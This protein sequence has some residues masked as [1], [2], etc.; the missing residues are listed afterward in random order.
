MNSKSCQQ[1][2]L[3]KK[4]ERKMFATSLRMNFSFTHFFFYMLKYENI[5]I[6]YTSN[7]E[8]ST[9]VPN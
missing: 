6:E 4:R 7:I 1:K 9:H 5:L 3:G 8:M 2:K